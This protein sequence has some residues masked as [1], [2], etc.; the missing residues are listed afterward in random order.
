VV[1]PELSK[2]ENYFEKEEKDFPAELMRLKAQSVRQ[3][4]AAIEASGDEPELI[5]LDR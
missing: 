3:A 2:I 1:I 4:I 5:K